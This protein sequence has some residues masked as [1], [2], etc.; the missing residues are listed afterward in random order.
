MIK[1]S[2]LY[3]RLSTIQYA[4][5]L[6]LIKM[7]NPKQG[8]NVLDIGSGTGALTFELAKLVANG[9]V[10]AIEPDINRLQYAQRLQAS[11]VDNIIWCDSNIEDF[12]PKNMLFNL[13]F[14][15]YVFHWIKNPEYVLKS[16]YNLLSLDG[17]FAFC[18]VLSMPCIL[19]DLCQYSG[20]NGRNILSALNFCTQSQWLSYFNNAGFKVESIAEIKYQE[21]K[22]LDQIMR[23][24][25]ATTHGIFSANQLSKACMKKLMNKYSDNIYREKVL[26]VIATK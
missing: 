23:W 10:V 14:S 9:K 24:W 18:C 22:T 21:I 26:Q 11:E 20:A 12:N 15:N 6:E 17:R 8:E 4:G 7:A 5:G 13:A 1:P 25:E 3:A 19:D 2:Q 16:I